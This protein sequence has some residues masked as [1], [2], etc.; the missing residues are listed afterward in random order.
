MK[1]LIKAL[2]VLALAA[3]LAAAPATPSQAH[4]ITLNFGHS[5]LPF[6]MWPD[7][8]VRHGNLAVRFDSGWPDWRPGHRA[9][10]ESRYHSY[11]PWSD[12][13][14][15]LDGDRHLCRL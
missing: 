14:L 13:F 11:D 6:F 3:G 9:R 5:A 7:V 4:G 8:S 1:H 10:C 12:T 2:G 15:G